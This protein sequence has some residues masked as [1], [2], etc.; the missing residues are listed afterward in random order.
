MEIAIQLHLYENGTMKKG[1]LL[2]FTSLLV[3]NCLTAQTAKELIYFDV[4]ASQLSVD[5]KKVLM[6]IRQ[7]IGTEK[8]LYLLINGYADSDGTPEFN[9]ALSRAR[10]EAVGR[11]LQSMGIPKWGMKIAAL[12]EQEPI[13]SNETNEGKTKNRRVEVIFERN[14]TNK[15]NIFSSWNKGSQYFEVFAQEEIVIKGREGTQVTFPKNSIVRKNGERMNGK[16]KIELKEF[17]KKS[18]MLLANLTTV[19][20]KEILET[21]GMVYLKV[22]SLDEELTVKEDQEITLQMAPGGDKN[23]MQTFNGQVHSD[24]VDWVPYTSTVTVLTAGESVDDDRFKGDGSYS[25]EKE[26]AD[27]LIITSSK[28]GWI[29]CDR[30]YK[31]PNKTQLLVEIDTA[32]KP[33]L[34][35]VFKDMNSI[36]PAYYNQNGKMSFGGIPI[37]Q[38]AT[39]IAFGNLNGEH[40]F[41]IKDI[42]ISTNHYEDLKLT[43]TNPDSIEVELKKL[44]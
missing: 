23:R 25:R 34:R 11:Y 4:A 28:L 6:T 33:V 31:Y 24:L 22:T 15:P 17:Y 7:N 29:N 32:Y 38:K 16:V 30:F 2:L 39:L 35:L 9:L 27:A 12:G 36:L 43:K 13:S 5:A 44:N 41:A 20:G 19:S 3:A 10:A 21:A 42:I 26:A 8:G 1:L 14:L 40:Y 18:D 37:G